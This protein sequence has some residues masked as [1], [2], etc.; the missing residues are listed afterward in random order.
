LL[1]NEDS[2]DWDG[3]Y[4]DIKNMALNKNLICIN[5]RL[6]F[7]NFPVDIF[8][9]FK[10]VYILTYMFDCQIQKYYYD[11]HG[12]EYEKYQVMNG[13]LV[14]YTAGRE[15]KRIEEI[16][17]L[18][19]IHDGQYNLIGDDKYS[20][21]L[22]WFEKDDGTLQ[23]ILGS[24]IYNWFNNANRKISAKYRLWTTFKDYKTKI[25]GKGYTNRFIALNIRATNEYR[26][27]HILAYCA[28]RFIRPTI[29][30][31]FSNKGISLNQDQYALS[32][33]LQWIWRSRIREGKD[34]K[35]YIPSKRMRE[36]L[37]TYLQPNSEKKL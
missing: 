14:E 17:K 18:I 31:F 15:N 32:E 27:T 10:E 12:I 19:S 34:I 24:N 4:S 20:L 37:I 29:V 8:N 9:Y 36:L 7:W 22:S 33:M 30:Q 6:L 1:W 2:I 5:G 26:N 28:N 35:I 23:G 16:A 11:F 25:A 13:E 3:R 21:S